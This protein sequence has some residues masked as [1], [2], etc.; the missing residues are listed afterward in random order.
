MIRRKWLTFLICALAAALHVSFRIYMSPLLQLSV[1]AI[2]IA[3][4]VELLGSIVFAARAWREF[5]AKALLPL[6]AC[7]LTIPTVVV[8]SRAAEA[9]QFRMQRPAFEKLIL[10]LA[11]EQK[12]RP[13]ESPRIIPT[14]AARFVLAERTGAGHLQVEFMTWVAYPVKHAGYVYVKQ[15]EV[16]PGSALAQRWP[17]RRRVNSQWFR[18][19]D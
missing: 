8:G 14:D 10:A 16:E 6:G 13:G 9:V 18:V 1:L 19:Y 11:S 5:K 17:Y 12:I 7:L 15:G 3:W 4:L 2:S